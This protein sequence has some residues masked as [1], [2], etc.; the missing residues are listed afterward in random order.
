MQ[1][2]ACNILR[3]ADAPMLSKWFYSVVP[4]L[5]FSLLIVTFFHRMA[6]SLET[7]CQNIENIRKDAMKKYKD[8]E[9]GDGDNFDGNVTSTTNKPCSIGPDGKNENGRMEEN[10]KDEQDTKKT[11]EWK[12]KNKDD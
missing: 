1:I 8:G 3:F 12:E 7:S 4:P 2:C 10:E 9:I 5:C 6:M 11:A